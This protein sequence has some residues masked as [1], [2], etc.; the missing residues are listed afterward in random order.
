MLTPK[1][2]VAKEGYPFIALAALF[3][4]TAALLSCPWT[5]LVLGLV[6][7]FV[8]WFFRDPERIIPTH[9]ENA[10]LCPADGA[11]IGV[12]R[13]DESPFIGGKTTRIS[14]FMNVFNVHVNRAVCAGRVEKVSHKPGMFFAADNKKA[15]LENES[16]A[17]VLRLASGR[18]VAMVQIAGLIARRIVCWLQVGDEIQGG[19]RFGLIRFGSRLDVYLPDDCQVTV[20]PGRKVKAGESVLAILP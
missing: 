12:D 4:L 1:I 18:Q 9:D 20:F 17:T 11:I 5:T 3:T 2:P 7:L 10:I 16:C 13:L 15:A 19:E 6:T 8:V 14:I